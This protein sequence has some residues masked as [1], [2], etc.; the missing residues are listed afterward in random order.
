MAYTSHG[1]NPAALKYSANCAGDTG[2]HELLPDP[3]AGLGW[4]ITSIEIVNTDTTNGCAIT[5]S[6]TSSS[7]G[8]L[9]CPP[10]RGCG[11]THQ[12]T[13]PV[14]FDR[15]LAVSITAS[16][17]VTTAYVSVIAYKAPV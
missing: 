6:T 14:P 13:K 9:Q 2:P 16:H 12:Y 15:H 5:F 11:S 1:E 8:P 4:M 7:F 17:A 10:G 3:G